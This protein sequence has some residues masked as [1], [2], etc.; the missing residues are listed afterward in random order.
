MKTSI[1]LSIVTVLTILNCANG[2]TSLPNNPS[3]LPDNF[4]LLI[5]PESSDGWIVLKDTLYVHPDSVFSKYKSWWG[6]N[7]NDEIINFEN[8]TDDQ[9]IDHVGYYRIHK[10]F[11]IE[12]C[13]TRIH[14]SLYAGAV[15][16]GN[17]GRALDVDIQKRITFSR[18][19][20]ISKLAS[21]DTLF[22]WEDSASEAFLKLLK[23][24]MA[25]YFPSEELIIWHFSGKS[26]EPNNFILAYKI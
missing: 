12:P 23:G 24:P 3:N 19:I 11:K 8:L 4:N 18:A 2:Q 13:V 16:N 6:F 20:E 14:A 15:I 26:Y 7:S 17:L 25:T 1:Y 10:G 5:S 21:N 9:N 22:K